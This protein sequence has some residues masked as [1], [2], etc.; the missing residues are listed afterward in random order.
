MN[1]NFQNLIKYFPL[2]K[3][4]F[5]LEKGS[6]HEF[7]MGND[8]LPATVFDELISPNLPFEIDEF[9]E[10]IPG[11]HWKTNS[12]TFVLAFWVARLMR[13]SFFLFSY[14]KDGEWIDDAEVAGFF[15][16]EGQ[17]IHRIA[18]INDPNTI[19]IVEAQ[20]EDET[21]LLN[22]SST[23]KWLIEIKADGKF[24]QMD[25]SDL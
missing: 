10:M 24:F 21:S 16:E 22:P 4:P 15:Y 14:S 19:Y 25:A 1:Q 8:L 18:N 12:E 2:A 17:I 20:L 6:E 3:L 7:G 11:V 5:T 23:S 13:H 9:T